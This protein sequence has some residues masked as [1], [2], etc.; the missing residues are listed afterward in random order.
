MTWF[1]IALV[2]PFLWAIVNIA[3]QYLIANYSEREKERSSGGLVIFS[4][5]IGIFIALLILIFTS[6]VFNIPFSDKVLLIVAGALTISWIILYLYTLEIEEVSNVIPWFLMVPVFGYIFGYLFLGETLSTHQSTGSLVIFSGLIL[7]S[8][9]FKEGKK[10]FK[11]KLALYMIYA[12]VLIA[13]SGILFKYVTVENNFWISSFWEYL[14]LGITGLLIFLFIP[15]HRN[16]FLYM[17]KKG[18][19]KI[20][21]VNVISELMSITGNLLTNFALLL[22]PVTLVYMVGSFQPAIVLVL[23]IFGTKFFPKIIKEDVSKRIL[24]PKIIAIIL[25]TTGSI[26]LFL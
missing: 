7:I 24:I 9:N 23:A 3:D 22:A 12:S 4:S 11:R 17:H 8:T 15:K 25:I 10:Y 21:F 14:G 6:D 26:F 20:F 13:I 18:G 2:A 19:R 5:I 16:E 1:L